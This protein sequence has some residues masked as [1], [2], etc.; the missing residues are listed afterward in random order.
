MVTRRHHW[1]LKDTKSRRMW[2]YKSLWSSSLRYDCFSVIHIW[3]F[4]RKLLQ[5]SV[6]VLFTLQ[7]PLF[8]LSNK[9]KRLWKKVEWLIVLFSHVYLFDVLGKEA[10]TFFSI[11]HNMRR[12]GLWSGWMDNLPLDRFRLTYTYAVMMGMKVMCSWSHP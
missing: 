10:C 4:H 2:F 8:E 11:V 1:S 5:P 6:I 7:P 3:I 9:L 12:S